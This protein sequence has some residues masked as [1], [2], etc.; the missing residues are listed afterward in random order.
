MIVITMLLFI[1]LIVPTIFII[2]I[3]MIAMNM[4]IIM[5]AMT[6]MD[7]CWIDDFGDAGAKLGGGVVELGLIR[8]SDHMCFE[9]PRAMW[10]WTKKRECLKHSGT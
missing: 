9:F 4:M 2:V 5:I 7:R 3:I 1:I 10:C 8:G 6:I